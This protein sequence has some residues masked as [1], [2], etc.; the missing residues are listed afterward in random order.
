MRCA[1]RRQGASHRCAWTRRFACRICFLIPIP[2]AGFWRRCLWNRRWTRRSGCGRMDWS[3]AKLE[4][5]ARTMEAEATD[6]AARRSLALTHSYG[7][8]DVGE[9]KPKVT[10]EAPKGAPTKES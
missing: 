8:V 9:P 3:T 10:R 2:A 7:R 4:A 5:L 6:D 1:G